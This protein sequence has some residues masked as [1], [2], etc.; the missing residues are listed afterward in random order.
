MGQ[1]RH[2]PTLVH[3]VGVF[4]VSVSAMGLIDDKW[5]ALLGVQ[6]EQLVKPSEGRERKQTETCQ[7]HSK[8]CNTHYS[9][10]SMGYKPN[11]GVRMKDSASSLVYCLE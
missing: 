7:K 2:I 11:A 6:N 9:Y 3:T 10:E 5:Y 1:E 4:T 8:Q